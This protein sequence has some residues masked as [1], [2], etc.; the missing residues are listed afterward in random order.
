MTPKERSTIGLSKIWAEGQGVEKVS[1]LAVIGHVTRRAF[2]NLSRSRITSSLT[3]VTIAVALSVLSFFALIVGNCAQSV[4]RESGD[5]S[6]MVFLRDSVTPIEVD[7]IKK[8][9]SDLTKGLTVSYTDKA[10]ALSSFRTMLGEDSS[11]LEG[12]D[13]QNPLPASLNIMISDPQRADKLFDDVSERLAPSTFIDSIRYSRSGVQQLKKLLR[14]V[15]VGGTVGMGFLLVITGFIIANTIK[16]ALYNHRMEI[17]IMELVGARR[18]SIYA[19][20]MLEGFGQGV[21]GACIGI[22]FVFSVYVLISHSMAQSELL[23]MVFPTFHFLSL[24]VLGGIVIAGAL[25]GMGGS[26]LAV[27]RFLAEQ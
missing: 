20:Y 1:I 19:P 8:E 9:L 13:S 25:V 4:Q 24:D 18:G 21:L 17:E 10:A 14:I 22:G 15:E 3:V 6:V 2:E 26:F 5:M 12:I 27:R 7:D 16:L 23:Q 11:M